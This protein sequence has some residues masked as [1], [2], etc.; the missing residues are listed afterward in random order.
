MNDKQARFVSEYLVDLNATQAAIRA[1]Y[2][3]RT[4]A[5]I[6]SENLTKPEIAS[7]IVMAKAEAAKR[8]EI[9]VDTITAMHQEAFDTAKT[10]GNASAMTTTANNLAKLHGLI[11]DK[12]EHKTSAVDDMAELMRQLSDELPD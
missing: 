7:A 5:S 11:I 1:G 8:N 10:S 6:G 12:R 2:S 4:A 3:E 9:T